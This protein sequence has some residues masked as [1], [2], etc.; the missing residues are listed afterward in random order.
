MCRRSL[1]H[2]PPIRRLRDL[3]RYRRALVSDR[4]REMQRVE[5]LL[6][7]A[8]IKISSVLSD[9]HGVS[10][11]A[12]M[13]ALIAGQ[14][15]P[16]SLARLAKGIARKKIDRLDLAQRARTVWQYQ[17]GWPSRGRLPP[18]T[19]VPSDRLPPRADASS[20]RCDGPTE[21]VS[22]HLS[23]HLAP[24]G[25]QFGREKSRRCLQN[26]IGPPQFGDLTPELLQ[27][28]RLLASSCPVVSRHR[29]GPGAPTCAPSR[30]SQPRVAA[31]PRWIAAHSDSC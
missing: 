25:A 4:S 14:R 13:E 24:R 28:S 8:Q 22:H 30:H 5:K 18:I 2:P 11:R 21:T 15:D 29:P 3:T 23:I 17:H 7:D 10:G 19:V 20:G 27:L 31:P 26:R 12:M 16:W 1:V 9:I 6:E